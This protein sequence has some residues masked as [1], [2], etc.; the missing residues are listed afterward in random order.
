MF[1]IPDEGK[2][3]SLKPIADEAPR[4]AGVGGGAERSPGRAVS[5][6][7][8]LLHQLLSSEAAVDS[9]GG[10]ASLPAGGDH[11]SFMSNLQIFN[12]FSE[13]IEPGLFSPELFK[14]SIHQASRHATT[15][16][17]SILK[18][19]FDEDHASDEDLVI[20]LVALM[21]MT[22]SFTYEH[23]KRVM[24]WSVSLAREAGLKADQV[25][26]IKRGA[27]FRDIG[28]TGVF[29]G[30]LEEEEREHAGAFLKKEMLS[31][32][33]CGEFHDIGKLQIPPEIVNKT[34]RLTDEEFDIMKEHPLIGEA[35]LKPIK[36]LSS[37][38]PAVRH[39]HERW[40]GKGYPDKL[41]GESIPLEARIVGITDSFD[42]MTADRP[43]RRAM[44]V[45]DATKELEK[46]AGCQFDP[47]LVEKFLKILEKD[48]VMKVL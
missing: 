26:D 6:E 3:F 33:V 35:I 27:F 22:S 46:N 19:S 30:S 23:S 5:A 47:L 18:K 12:K 39:H 43:Y 17:W 24:E 44:S 1:S 42:A 13:Y 48:P 20:L 10:E 31:F 15:S 40:D 9:A 2:H 45:A 29:F 32:R 14:E 34:S 8:S 38:L 36:S 28:K 37:I 16:I 41:S 4:T 21:K 25:D 11:G 7:I